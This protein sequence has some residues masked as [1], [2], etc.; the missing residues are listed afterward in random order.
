MNADGSQR[1][2]IRGLP[3]ECPVYI[4][5]SITDNKHILIRANDGSY[6]LEDEE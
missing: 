1:R 6:I 5:K 4:L 3:D 2:R